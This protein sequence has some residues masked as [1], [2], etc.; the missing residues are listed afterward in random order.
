MSNNQYLGRNIFAF[1]R[2]CNFVAF[3]IEKTNKIN[4]IIF[5]IKQ[6]LVFTATVIFQ[7]TVIILHAIFCAINYVNGTQLCLIIMQ[8]FYFKNTVLFVRK[9]LFTD[10]NAIDTRPCCFHHKICVD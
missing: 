10:S 8:H 5:C 1:C 9:H 7:K 2:V 3:L 4:K 6:R